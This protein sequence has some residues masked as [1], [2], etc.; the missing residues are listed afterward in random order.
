MLVNGDSV[1]NITDAVLILKH[2]TNSDVPFPV[3]TNY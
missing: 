1:I 2:I 3:E